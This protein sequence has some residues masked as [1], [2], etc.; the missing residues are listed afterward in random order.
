MNPTLPTT[1][2]QALALVMSSTFRAF[3]SHDWAAYAGCETTDPK[4]CEREDGLIILVDGGRVEFMFFDAEGHAL[5][6]FFSLKE[7]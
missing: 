5:D 1:A 3:T 4:I 6:A 2:A 7:G